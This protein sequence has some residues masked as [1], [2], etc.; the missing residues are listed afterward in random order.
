[1]TPRLRPSRGRQDQEVDLAR[2][3]TSA[4]TSSM[5]GRSRQTAFDD[6]ARSM[7]ARG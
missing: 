6:R 1:M 7:T 3:W 2:R 4:F 5:T